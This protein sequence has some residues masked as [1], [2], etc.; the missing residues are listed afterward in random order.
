MGMYTE[1]HFNAEL[2]KSTP[3]HV[4]K[5]LEY[6]VKCPNNYNSDFVPPDHALFKLDDRRWCYMLQSDSYY[7]PTDT[8][9]TL[10]LDDISETYYLCIRCNLKNYQQ[11]IQHFLDWVTPYL[12]C[13]DGDFLGFY[14]YEDNNQ[15]ALLHFETIGA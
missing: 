2:K 6:M 14:R 10:R 13:S 4:I 15:P 12:Y 3:E 5:T 9:S 8:H 1:F 11:E 7:F